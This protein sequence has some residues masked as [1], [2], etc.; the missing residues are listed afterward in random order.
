MSGFTRYRGVLSINLKLSTFY[1][2][3]III[4]AASYL[5]YP[6]LMLLVWSAIFGGS[7]VQEIGGFM[8]LQLYAYFFVSFA[9]TAITPGV[10]DAISSDIETGTITSDL[11]L[12]VSYVARKFF[13]GIPSTAINLVFITIP[14]LLITAVFAQVSLSPST[15]LAV[16][17][18]LVLLYFIA[19]LIDLML[20]ITSI[21][22]V[23]V[24]GIGS[25]ITLLTFLSGG[26]LPITFF[27]QAVQNVLQI[28][29]FNAYFYNPAATFVGILS[30]PA[31]AN[32]INIEVIWVA[33]LLV[34]A[35][36]YWQFSKSRIAAVGG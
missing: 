21:Y 8:P 19:F 3:N 17:V 23:S 4:T 9:A 1:I 29:P 16:A 24:E 15:L 7:G 2:N 25:A 13:D 5:S 6:I 14:I 20:G 27:P 34:L 36:L 18:E 35:A 28:L 32:A 26:I 11:V 33:V 10:S 12:P 22:V 31:L 30:G